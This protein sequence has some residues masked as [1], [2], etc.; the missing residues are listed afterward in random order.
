ME[1]F[2]KGNVVVVPFPFSDLSGTKKRPALIVANI[3][4]NDYILCE[5]TTVPVTD[6]YSILLESIDFED[7]GLNKSSKIRPN[8]I[9]TLDSSIIFYSTGKLKDYKIKEVED[10]L[11]KL[12]KQ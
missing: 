8:K 4:S 11:I 1:R 6:N 2:V 10:I 7:G 12:F 9:F 5:I 3:I